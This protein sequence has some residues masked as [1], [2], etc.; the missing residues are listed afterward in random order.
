MIPLISVFLSSHQFVNNFLDPVAVGHFLAIV[1]IGDK[2][3]VYLHWS[4][5]LYKQFKN[6]H[7]PILT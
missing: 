7:S 4:P 5:C 6:T 2:Y 1:P 3:V